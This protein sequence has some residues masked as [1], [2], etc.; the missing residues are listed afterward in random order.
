VVIVVKS[1]IYQL[2]ASL[3]ILKSVE[4]TEKLKE[5]DRSVFRDDPF[6]APF[7]S[8]AISLLSELRSAVDDWLHRLNAASTAHTQPDSKA[9]QSAPELRKRMTL[10]ELKEKLLKPR[11]GDRD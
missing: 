6:W 9:G 5:H 2:A 3:D 8:P 1:S 4:C 10:K 11:R 7:L